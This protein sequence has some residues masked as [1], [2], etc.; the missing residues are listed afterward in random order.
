MFND[1]MIIPPSLR[2]V[3]SNSRNFDERL[4][5]CKRLKGLRIMRALSIGAGVQTTCHYDNRSLT[6]SN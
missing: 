2:Y 6:V 1:E 5:I 3:A 4:D